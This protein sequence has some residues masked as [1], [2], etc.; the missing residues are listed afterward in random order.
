MLLVGLPVGPPV[1][2]LPR[3]VRQRKNH[4][5]SGKYDVSIRGA[6]PFRGNDDHWQE[7]AKIDHDQVCDCS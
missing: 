4:D 7:V 2:Q 3:T 5:S 1:L 6:H